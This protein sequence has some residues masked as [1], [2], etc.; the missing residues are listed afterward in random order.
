M[1]PDRRVD[2]SGGRS[3]IT[4]R[5]VEKKHNHTLAPSKAK[6]IVIQAVT[7]SVITTADRLINSF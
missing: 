1:E 3:R 7:I 5:A 2:I 4:L 6:T